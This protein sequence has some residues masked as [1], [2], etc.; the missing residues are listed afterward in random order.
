MYQE[1]INDYTIAIKIEP[2]LAN[3]YNNR[4]NAFEY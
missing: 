3:S 1:A 4:G 2:N